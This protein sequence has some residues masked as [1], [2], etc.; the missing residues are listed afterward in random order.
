VTAEQGGRPPQVFTAARLHHLVTGIDIYPKTVQDAVKLSQEKYCAA[1]AMLT[2][3]AKLRT[4]F[5]VIPE[6]HFGLVGPSAE[7]GSALK[8]SL[9][10]KVD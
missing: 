3:T 10:S 1:E 6:K 5:E 2:Y 4:T 8:A 9:G 7:A